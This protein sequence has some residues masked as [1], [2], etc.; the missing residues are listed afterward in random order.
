MRATRGEL[1]P[2]TSQDVESLVKAALRSRTS[3]VTRSLYTLKAFVNV[4]RK[5]LH[6]ALQR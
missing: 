4:A 6:P 3:F 2:L 5:Y 1:T